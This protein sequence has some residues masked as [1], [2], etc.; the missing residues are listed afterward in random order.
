[1]KHSLLMCI[2]ACRSTLKKY[3]QTILYTIKQLASVSYAEF[4]CAPLFC[5]AS[6]WRIVGGNGPLS[7]ISNSFA[8]S[9][10]AASLLSLSESALSNLQN[11]CRF[12]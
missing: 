5:T 9:L 1:M 11:Q 4:P 3:P 6:I 7:V 8:A 12:C 2:R 10:S